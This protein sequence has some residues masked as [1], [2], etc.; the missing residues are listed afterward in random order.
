MKK[1][2]KA[3]CLLLMFMLSVSSFTFYSSA[4][5]NDFC[6]NNAVIIIPENPSITDKY[7]AD[8]LKYYLDEI[9]GRDIEISADSEY[10]EYE[11]CVGATNRSDENFSSTADGSYI[12]KSDT[13]RVIIN[14]AGNKGSINGVY[15][16]LEKYC[17]CHWYEAEVIVIFRNRYNKCKRSGIFGCKRT[18]GRYI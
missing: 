9:T 7:A 14:G 12:I 5:D 2:K 10:S 1:C 4:E 8:R 18:Y 16:F 11:I 15:A 6:V 17:G 13:N 3:L